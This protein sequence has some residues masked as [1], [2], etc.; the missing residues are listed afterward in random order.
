MLDGLIQNVRYTLR[1]LGNARGFTA[2]AVLTL[3]LG[4]GSS[5]AIFSVVHSVLFRPLGY[6]A[7][8]RLIEVYTEFP[9]QGVNGFRRFWASRPEY[10]ELKKDL[11]SWQTFDAW[12]ETGAN[13][14]GGAAAGSRPRRARHWNSTCKRWVCSR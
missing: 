4:I 6:A 3:G 8:D 7:P 13:I 10:L 11:S 2:I 1:T 12:A 9:K 5:T 14:G